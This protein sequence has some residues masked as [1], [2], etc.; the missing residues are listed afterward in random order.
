MKG[1]K[2]LII[3]FAA[4]VLT[5]V[6][7]LIYF[8]ATDAAFL[9]KNEK[10]RPL[11][12]VAVYPGEIELIEAVKTY[13]SEDEE[14]AFYESNSKEMFSAAEKFFKEVTLSQKLKD[15][16]DNAVDNASSVTVYETLSTVSYHL[17]NGDNNGEISELQLCVEKTSGSVI[18]FYAVLKHVDDLEIVSRQMAKDY[19]K[20]TSLDTLN[21]WTFDGQR[22]YSK[23]AG[24][25]LNI[26]TDGENGMVYLGLEL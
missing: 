2:K 24:L 11:A 15:Y 3:L 23:K 20:Y 18:S 21:D 25:Y 6:L 7:P 16:I 1:K 22:Y 14:S 19:L 12:D 8:A 4:A 13:L 26:E 10:L 17:L 9:N 5:A